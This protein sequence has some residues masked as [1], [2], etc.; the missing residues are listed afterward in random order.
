MGFGDV[1][2]G[3]LA[4]IVFASSRSLH[5]AMSNKYK[6]RSPKMESVSSNFEVEGAE[7]ITNNEDEIERI[8]LLVDEKCEG[9]VSNNARTR[10]VP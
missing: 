2:D 7:S 8:E 3:D 4:L 10:E 6:G 1:I 5:I 9:W